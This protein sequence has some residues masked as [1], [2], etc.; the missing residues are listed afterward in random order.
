M[1]KVCLLWIA[2]GILFL[3][4]CSYFMKDKGETAGQSQIIIEEKPQE[5]TAEEIG[6][7]A[8]AIPPEETTIAPLALPDVS[9]ETPTI[10][11]KIIIASDIHYLAKELTDFGDAFQ[12]MEEQGDGKVVSYIWE[13]TEAF[14]D[15]VIEQRPQALI[16]SG[17]L[18]LNGE[19]LSH[20]ALA[21]ELRRVER[22]GIQVVVIPG[23]HDINNAAAASFKASDRIP[24]ATTSPEQ[25]AEIY[26][27]YGYNEALDRDPASLSYTYELPDGTWLLMLDSCQY[28]NGAKVGGMIRMDTYDWID[29]VMSKAWEEERKII[30]VA[31]HNILDESRIY[32][33]DCTIEHAEELLEKLNDWDIKLFLSG[34][35]HVQHGRYSEEYDI[36]EI[37]TSALSIAPCQYGVLQYFGPD[38]YHYTTQ[39]TDVTAWAEKKNNPDMNL[40]DFEEYSESFLQNIFYQKA[41]AGLKDKGLS[42]DDRQSMAELYALL[43]VYSVAGRAYEVKEGVMADPSYELWQEFSRSSIQC[44][45]MNEILEDAETNYNIVRKP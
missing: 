41:F 38:H 45:Y 12:M 26:A 20:E 21:D 1:K 33:D 19:L 16:L 25:F 8:G 15:E 5:T 10:N 17:D 40:Q 37:V 11:P 23:N 9:T 14:L 44:M 36:E 3:S 24:A 4:G 27:D 18:T 32:E 7:T 30:A 22:A 34:H 13:V 43:N 6:P 39:R 28:E 35:L 2:A 42:P 29:Q 31:H